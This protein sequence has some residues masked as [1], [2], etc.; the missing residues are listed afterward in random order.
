MSLGERLLA[1]SAEL[2]AD[3]AAQE[4]HRNAL[5]LPREDA[6]AKAAKEPPRA[7][8]LV[9][10]L[11]QALQSMDDSL[12]EHC[13]Q[14]NDSAIIE[15]TIDRMP[16]AR[17]LLLLSRLV[18]KFEKRPQR[19]AVLCTWIRSVLVRHTGYLLS[20][21]DLSVRLGRLHQMIESR[22]STFTR[23]LELD[24]RLKQILAHAP[25]SS[26]A[27]SI[28][29]KAAM[30]CVLRGMDSD[31]SDDETDEN[32]AGDA[33]RDG[34]D[35]DSDGVSEDGDGDAQ[36]DGGSSEGAADVLDDEAVEASSGAEDEQD[37]GEDGVES[38]GDDDDE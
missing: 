6:Q 19:G 26:A 16:A 36:S 3:T 2:E 13:L 29:S 15:A 9:T 32:D 4:R 27:V 20:I 7:D 35:G 33:L 31:V 5:G 8:S 37:E 21:P 34:S 30:T 14:V 22:L 17:V 24:G 23:F 10:V 18:A 38:A 1:L 11:M 25:S 12:L 28:V